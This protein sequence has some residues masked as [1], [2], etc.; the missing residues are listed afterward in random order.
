MLFFPIEVV[1]LIFV[2]IYDEVIDSSASSSHVDDDNVA[3]P[4]LL[5]D[6]DEDEDNDVVLQNHHSTTIEDSQT[7][8][9]SSDDGQEDRPETLLTQLRVSDSF[10]R[11]K[12]LALKSDSD[13]AS[14]TTDDEKV[15]SDERLLDSKNPILCS[16]LS[17][18]CFGPCG[19]KLCE[20]RTRWQVCRNNINEFVKCSKV[21]GEKCQESHDGYCRV[22]IIAGSTARK[23]YLS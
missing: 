2:H 12:V 23:R 13:T 9:S 20:D 6:S 15:V 17:L 7:K 14:S 5:Y 1:L 4:E 10:T 19:G 21:V 18:K 8:P 22:C 11:N 16:D 3:M